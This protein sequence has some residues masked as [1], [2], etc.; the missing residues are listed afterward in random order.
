M[1]RKKSVV[2][3]FIMKQ[4]RGRII[5]KNPV[6]LFEE[7]R[8]VK[9][10]GEIDADT[11]DLVEI[12]VQK[13]RLI[14]NSRVLVKSSGSLNS[15]NLDIL[16]QNYALRKKQ[17]E[18]IWK[19]RKFFHKNGF[20]EA[21]TAILKDAIIPEEHIE[22][23]RSENGQFLAA[24]PELSLKKLLIGGFDKI[25]ELTHAFRNDN[26]GAFHNKEFIIAEW[27]R[28]YCKLDVIQNDFIELIKYLAEG[29]K[30]IW[31][32]K[33][34]ELKAEIISFGDA[35]K[36]AG[37]EL[38]HL[39]KYFRSG[40]FDNYS[41]YE[42]ADYAFERY[43]QPMLGNGNI[44]FLVDFPEW[45]S[46]LAVVENHLT[47][48]FEAFIEGIE[49]ANAFYELNDRNEQKKRFARE[50]AALKKRGVSIKADKGFI[51]ALGWGMPE[52]SGIAVGVDRLLL[53]LT[54]Q[55][56]IEKLL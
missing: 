37:M 14:K 16:P 53:F 30:I 18:L 15:N 26:P 31:Q 17:F 51:D 11:G 47:K 8:F 6:V 41:Y 2:I 43:V 32:G 10:A 25:F 35:F 23:I 49:L 7:G 42:L 52:A 9:L 39:R 36:K 54:N 44:T 50:E 38:E 24:S 19:I 27:Y 56:K 1:S 48:R 5:C 3:Y 40:E 22:P 12:T 4:L 20:I 46:A 21:V 33:K 45:K 55:T 34:I 13:N 29:D 28:A